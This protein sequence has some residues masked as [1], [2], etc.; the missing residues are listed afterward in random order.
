M[1]RFDN[2]IP[3]GVLQGIDTYDG[4]VLL[5]DLAVSLGLKVVIRRLEGL[6]VAVR[7]VCIGYHNSSE[8]SLGEGLGDDIVDNELA[9]L[10]GDLLGV[11]LLI[12]PV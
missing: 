11:A 8:S 1:D 7:N 9:F 5:E 10:L 2:L 4:E 12:N 3:Q 6:I